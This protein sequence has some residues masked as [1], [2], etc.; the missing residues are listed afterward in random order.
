MYFMQYF[1]KNFIVVEGGNTRQES[2]KNALQFVTSP[3]VMVTDVARACISKE[4][5]EKLIKK[6]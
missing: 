1:D 5:I 3:Y 2:M 4:I 6:S